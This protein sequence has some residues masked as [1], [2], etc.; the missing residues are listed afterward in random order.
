M[1]GGKDNGK[2]SNNLSSS[3]KMYNDKIESNFVPIEDTNKT[4]G[5]N[6]TKPTFDSM[7]PN[8][9]NSEQHN[10]TLESYRSRDKDQSFERNSLKNKSGYQAYQD[11]MN[12]DQ[13][14][15]GAP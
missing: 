1:R 7:V 2:Y 9:L 6:N 11:F 10:K 5:F 12:N 14:K 4:L 3:E 8:Y 13:K 15:Q